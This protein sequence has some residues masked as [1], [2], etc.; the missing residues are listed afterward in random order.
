MRPK[1]ILFDL[2]DTLISPHQHRTIFWRE[3]ITQ[4]W[5]ETHGSEG[6]LPHNLDVVVRAIDGP[7]SAIISMNRANSIGADAMTRLKSPR[8]W[9]SPSWC[10]ISSRASLSVSKKSTCSAT[11]SRTPL[12][13]AADRSLRETTTR[14]SCV[15]RW[16][17]ENACGSSARCP[18]RPES[19]RICTIVRSPAASAGEIVSAKACRFSWLKTRFISAVFA[20]CNPVN[21]TPKYSR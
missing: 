8:S 9:L 10:P 19:G 18:N 15:S 6:A 1:A 7:A 14:R 20:R 21:S 2:D 16:R 13:Y 11:R 12:L 5:I 4:I 17:L 3:A